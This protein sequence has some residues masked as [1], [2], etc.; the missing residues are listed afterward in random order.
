MPRCVCPR[1]T[2]F[3]YMPQ[4]YLDSDEAEAEWVKECDEW[5]AQPCPHAGFGVE[6]R[7][8]YALYERV[9]DEEE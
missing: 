6:K 3:L 1:C 5:L 4:R 9:D 7:S 2:A 8:Q